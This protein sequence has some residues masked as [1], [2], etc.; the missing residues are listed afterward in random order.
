VPRSQGNS[1]QRYHY[2]ASDEYLA[3]SDFVKADRDVQV[4]LMRDWFYQNYGYSG[5]E[6]T[7]SEIGYPYELEDDLCNPR[8]ELHREFS[9]LVPED[10]IEGLASELSRVS[11]EWR[12]REVDYWEL[13]QYVLKA[14]EGSTTYELTFK[15]A[16]E[17]IKQLLK[18]RLQGTLEQNFLRMLYANVITALESFLCDCFVSEIQHDEKLKRKLIERTEKFQSAK[19]PM[20]D[21]FKLYEDI[22]RVVNEFLL[23]EISWHNLPRVLLLFRNVLGVKYDDKMKESLIRAIKIRHD[24]VHRNGKDIDGN[25]IVITKKQIRQLLN[26]VWV[27][28]DSAVVVEKSRDTA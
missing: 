12:A 16:L 20:S 17:T 19:I 8:A 21:V 24:I 5:D 14:I 27:F 26:L 22:D 2:F 13:D 9:G 7:Y 15:E 3:E 23:Q 11:R 10:V 28:L 25:E 4:R 6:I 18:E 1:E